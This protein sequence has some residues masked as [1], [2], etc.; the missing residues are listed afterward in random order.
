MLGQYYFVKSE[1][2]KAIESLTKATEQGYSHIGTW[3]V[4]A[5]CY[6]F[7]N[8]TK[9]AKESFT[10]ALNLAPA[11]AD[12]HGGLAIIAKIEGDLDL[13]RHLCKKA[14]RLDVNSYTAQYAHSLILE[15]DGQREQADA[16]IQKIIQDT[17]RITGLPHSVHL[18]RFIAQQ[19]K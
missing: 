7:K 17:N 3:H 15:V 5:W 9:Q 1:F 13:A 16:L 14:L 8:Q 4:L 12:S 19:N 2:D 18:K 11:F 6:L 10:E